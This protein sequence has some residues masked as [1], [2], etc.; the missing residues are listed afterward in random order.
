MALSTTQYGYIIDPMVPFTDG[1]GNT[2]KDGFVRVFVAGSSTP[3]ITYRNFD[4]AANPDKIEL[5]SSGRTMTSVIG[6]KGF[7]YKVC[8]YDLQHSQES[9]IL[10]VD[11]VSVIGANI[12]A[13]DGAT[14]V[15]GLDGLRTKPD[16]FVDASVIGTDG[17]VALDHT[18]VD[19]DLDT[20]A[21]AT[22]V[23]ND[24]YIPLLNNDVNDPDSKITLE[25]LW[26]WVL[27]KIKDLSTTITSFRT[28]DVIPVDGPSGTAKMAKDDLLRVTAENAGD[29]LF[30]G[31]P[32]KTE[33]SPTFTDARAYRVLPV[34]QFP[35][36][37]VQNS[38]YFKIAHIELADDYGGKW[39]TFK[40]C[41]HTANDGTIT[42]VGSAFLDEDGKVLKTIPI[43]AGADSV[44]MDCIQIPNGCKE[45]YITYPR[46]ETFA[47]YITDYNTTPAL[48]L[49]RLSEKSVLETLDET[50]LCDYGD[51]ESD[52]VYNTSSKLSATSLIDISNVSKIEFTA[53]G[54]GDLATADHVFQLLNENLE[55]LVQGQI[56]EAG[57]SEIVTIDVPKSCK[58][59][60]TTYWNEAQR[61]SRGVTWYCKLWHINEIRKRKN[62]GEYHFFSPRVNQSVNRFWLTNSDSSA[63]PDDYK[64]TTSVLSLPSTYTPDGDAVP[65]ILY[66]HG[67]SHYVYYNAW[68]A[69]ADFRQQKKNFTDAGFAV[70]DCNGARNNNRQGYFHCAGSPQAIDAVLKTL[71]YVWKNYNVQHK[72]CCV[73]GSMGGIIGLNFL[74]KHP[75][76]INCAVILSAN[77]DLKATWQSDYDRA[78]FVEFLGFDDTTSYEDVKAQGCDPMKNIIPVGEDGVMSLPVPCEIMEDGNESSDPSVNRLIAYRA[79]A[80]AS[81]S[82][83]VYREFSDLTHSEVV[84]GGNAVVDG[85]IV[86]FCRQNI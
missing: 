50:E 21:K 22:A 66:F 39:F 75:N 36:Y 62:S 81:G 72:V 14:V 18:L 55:V 13:G 33:V 28:S 69:N 19:D 35:R 84:S 60:R 83:C 37:G 74:V 64:Q 44:F 5:D 2:I 3:I 17:Y 58:W 31:D 82:Y 70:I 8:V 85:E 12:T 11:K 16:G 77:C 68:G 25:R 52:G 61:T 57:N 51:I 47:G 6:S 40:N 26:Q 10:T 1:K 53:L 54:R 45:I 23:E 73:I 67:W 80:Q 48:S 43:D 9:P 59:F 86:A 76:L 32:N 7:T 71:D 42:C 56:V 65:V 4:G 63:H 46:S 24:R 78:S 20:D 79:A 29:Y 38:T 30:V 34:N 15:T 27:G 49:D 41:T